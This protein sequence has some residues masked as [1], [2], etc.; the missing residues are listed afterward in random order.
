MAAARD[1]LDPPIADP[2]GELPGAALLEAAV[3]PAA[4]ARLDGIK[5]PEA[6]DGQEEAEH[7]AHVEAHGDPSRHLRGF[8]LRVTVGWHTLASR[9]GRLSAAVVHVNVTGDVRAVMPRQCPH[10]YTCAVAMGPLRA[11]LTR[12]LGR[13]AERPQAMRLR[14]LSGRLS[15][16]APRIATASCT[17]MPEIGR[18]YRDLVLRNVPNYVYVHRPLHFKQLE[19]PQTR[20]KHAAIH[21]KH[22]ACVVAT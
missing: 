17:C 10:V 4:A 14:S 8:G 20:H 19:Q 16:E 2:D 18:K 1:A 5:G 3:A 7:A 9:D 12:T 22:A 21:A 13:A 6:E 11:Q 15:A